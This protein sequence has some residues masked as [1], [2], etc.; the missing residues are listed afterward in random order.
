MLLC[1][2][3]RSPGEAGRQK[4]LKDGGA[5]GSSQ[6]EPS[7]DEFD[8]RKCDAHASCVTREQTRCRV[9]P[10]RVSSPQ[11]DL[12]R[13]GLDKTPTLLEPNPYAGSRPRD[14]IGLYR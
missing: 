9:E 13:C 8:R 5:K 12:T 3:T 6:F 7:S 11:V 2:V 1:K 10:A 14:I 4:K